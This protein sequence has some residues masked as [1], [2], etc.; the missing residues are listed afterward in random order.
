MK[1]QLN[2]SKH[3]E[4][5]RKFTAAFRANKFNSKAKLEA[6]CLKIQYPFMFSSM[7]EGDLIAG[8][9]EYPL[10]YFL[11]QTYSRSDGAGFGYI[12]DDS[13][14]GKLMNLILDDLKSRKLI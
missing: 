12:F 7:K 11:P 8:R 3:L 5:A 13:V 9:Y 6:E 14:Y 2:K 10:V 4:Y 1:T